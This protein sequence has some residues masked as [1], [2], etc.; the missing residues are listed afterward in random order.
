MPARSIRVLVVEDYKLW[1][2]YICSLLQTK[3]EFCVV[4][5]LADGLEA[6]QK[7]KELK[8][9]LI[10]LDIGL[11]SLNGIEA[12]RQI[13]KLS[14]NSKI[15]FLSQES[16]ADIVAEVLRLGALGYVVKAHAGTE[17][18]AAVEA[19]SQGRQ[20][21]SRGLSG[22]HFAHTADVQAPIQ[23]TGITRNHQVGFHN[24]GAA[25]LL[26][27]TCFIEAALNAGNAVIVIATKSHLNGLAQGLQERGHDCAAALEQGRYIPLDVTDVLTSFM[28]NGMPDP[29]QL[30]RVA[31]DLLTEAAKATKGNPPRVA[32][33]GECSPILWSEGNAD[34][35]IRLEHLWDEIGKMY[36][37]DILCGYVL[38]NFQREHERHTYEGICAEHS[39]VRSQ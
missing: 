37:V 22:P 29:L 21:V 19:V 15:L 33:C 25:F 11:P 34:G 27:F 6:V 8:P 1:R 36:D 9:D 32:V 23:K 12:A 16:S 7:A 17:L 18:L 14:P 26:D 30:Q 20:F 35:A 31:G 38:T 13:R 24:D 39:A 10:L 28:I 4:S 5:D 2:D 3:P